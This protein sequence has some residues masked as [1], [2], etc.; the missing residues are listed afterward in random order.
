[1]PAATVYAVGRSDRLAARGMLAAGRHTVAVEA[2]AVA[3][4]P[5][6]PCA[7]TGTSLDPPSHCQ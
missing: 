2:V 1:V 7:G 6:I 5:A 3:V 4:L